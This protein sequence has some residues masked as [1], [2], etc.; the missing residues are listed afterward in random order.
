M[1]GSSGADRR[2]PGDPSFVR[3]RY[4]GGRHHDWRYAAFL[5]DR[6]W[7]HRVT[8][9][10]HPGTNMS[11]TQTPED[12]PVAR[13]LPV[14]RA[15]LGRLGLEHRVAPRSRVSRN[16]CPT[17]ARRRT[18]APSV[19]IPGVAAVPRALSSS[20][21]GVGTGFAVNRAAF[22]RCSADSDTLSSPSL[23]RFTPHPGPIFHAGDGYSTRPRR[24]AGRVVTDGQK[25]VSGGMFRSGPGSS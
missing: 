18:T 7:A 11:S 23:P 1:L 8:V 20:A 16:S 14:S 17:S 21:S 22:R 2:R 24:D 9:S 15:R 4:S 10:R 19:T 3:G 12:R 25:P 5:I 6:T 13:P